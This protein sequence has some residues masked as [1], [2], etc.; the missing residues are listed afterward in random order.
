MMDGAR[1][2]VQCLH[3]DIGREFING[4]VVTFLK[5]HGIKLETTA[6]Y[7]PQ[8]NGQVVREREM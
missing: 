4:N 2:G 1:N 6:P 5:E 3:S 7:T 8:Q